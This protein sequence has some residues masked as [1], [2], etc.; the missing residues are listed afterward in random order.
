M[1]NGVYYL[2]AILIAN[3]GFVY[4]P[5]IPL[6]GGEMFAPMSLLVGFVFV[7][8]D[9]VQ[10]DIGH[11]VLLYMVGGL[12]LSYMLADPYVALAS[13]V[14][15]ALSETVDWAVFTYTS[16]PIKDRILV[17][18]ALST[19]IDSAAFM[20]MAG[21]FSWYGFAVMTASKMLGA[22]LVWRKL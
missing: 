3:I 4:I 6:P 7:V 1:K 12:A 18:S 5:M 2:L 11:K 20:L 17:S 19:P 14:A 9:F 8:R 15:F 16:K 10:R 21:F 22:Y 13:A